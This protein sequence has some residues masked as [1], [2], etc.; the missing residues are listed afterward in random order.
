MQSSAVIPHWHVTADEHGRWDVW[1]R[2]DL[3]R[4]SHEIEVAKER[5]LI[6]DA[7]SN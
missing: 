1:I 5:S 4:T 2:W 6:A 3:D 7:S